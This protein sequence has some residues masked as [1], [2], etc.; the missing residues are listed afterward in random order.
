MSIKAL[1]VR[2][3]NLYP[4]IQIQ[5]A[6]KLI[7]QN[8]FAGGHF[9]ENE[10][11]TL[12]KLQTEWRYLEQIAP[13]RKTTGD[14]F[15]D[16][17]NN[18]CRLHL[19]ALKHYSISLSTINR[20]FINTANSV[21]GSIK[22]FEEKLDE[23]RQC[24]KEGQ[25]PFSLEELEAC[26]SSYKEKGYPPISHSEVYRKA[27]FPAYRIVRSEYCD[28]FELFCRIDSLMK[29]KD[30]VNVA[31]DGNCGAGKTTLSLLIGNIYDCNIFHMD[32]FFLTPEMKTEERL[33]EVGGNVDYAR[34]KNEVIDGLNSGSEFQY[35]KYD[36]KQ[37][38]FGPPISVIPKKLNI[39]EGS[40]SMHPTLVNNYD[41]KVFLHIDEEKQI[42]R[43]LN[44]N[45]PLMLKRFINEWI[46]MENRY[47]SELKI[48]EQCDLVFEA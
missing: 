10:E 29:V 28:F 41:L 31:I 9:I 15:E 3:Y 11:E 36:C 26:L 8:E 13:D 27:Y 37:M 25:L 17:G 42:S 33:N 34:F 1:L 23:L 35:R 12:R 16:I 45:G 32:D 18:L 38:I 47:F 43:I 39:I 48:Q 24:C 40:Y 4:R 14:V 30:R 21:R 6:V 2:H 20:L 19:A 44:R 5:D 7:Y 46:P 22:G